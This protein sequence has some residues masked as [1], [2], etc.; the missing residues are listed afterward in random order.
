MGVPGRHD[1]RARVEGST[2]GAQ[3]AEESIAG[4]SAE[5]DRAVALW[6]PHDRAAFRDDRFEGREVDDR[7]PQVV[8]DAAGNEE[9]DEARL[10]HRFSAAATSG[11]R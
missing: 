8:E 7:D 9:S 2:C 5:D 1:D 6:V 11:A 10:A 3:P 4:R